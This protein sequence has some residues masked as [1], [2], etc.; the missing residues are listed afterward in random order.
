[1]WALIQCDWGPYKKGGTQQVGIRVRLS[2][3]KETPGVGEG[4]GAQPSPASQREQGPA[5]TGSPTSR[6]AR[7]PRDNTCLFESLR[8]WYWGTA[9][10]TDP[11]GVTAEI[12]MN[13]Y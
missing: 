1:M 10:L 7:S 6:E 13:L 12:E 8:L 11:C 3:A 5:C 9:A 4:S 2:Q